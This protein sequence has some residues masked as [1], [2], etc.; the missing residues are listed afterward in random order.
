MNGEIK[1]LT[2]DELYKKLQKNHDLVI[3]NILSKKGYED[4][5]IKN[6]INISLNV[7]DE[8]AKKWSKNKEI[9]IYC[10]GHDCTDEPNIFDILKQMGFNNIYSYDGGM[11]EWHRK[12]YPVNE[13]C[14]L[15]YEK[16]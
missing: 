2:A 12:H 11:D 16:K 5:H 1:N 6:C 3:L 8:F 9:I 4:C 14:E 10:S 7:L 13:P 15:E